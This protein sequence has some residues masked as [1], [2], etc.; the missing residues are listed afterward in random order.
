VIAAFRT[1]DQSIPRVVWPRSFHDTDLTCFPG[2]QNVDGPVPAVLRSGSLRGADRLGFR[3]KDAHTILGHFRS[4]DLY[5]YRGAGEVEKAATDR[6]QALALYG[7]INRVF[8]A[9]GLKW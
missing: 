5:A 6:A 8:A 3:G 9:Y 1:Q 4:K 2:I 7:P